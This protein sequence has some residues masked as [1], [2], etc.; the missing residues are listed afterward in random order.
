[1]LVYL[2]G[3]ITMTSFL[4]NTVSHIRSGTSPVGQVEALQPPAFSSTVLALPERSYAIHPHALTAHNHAP[5]L[6]LV[7]P[8]PHSSSASLALHVKTL[9]AVVQHWANVPPV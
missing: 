6:A 3:P 2:I 7:V 5:Q 9:V 8:K 4:I 1:M